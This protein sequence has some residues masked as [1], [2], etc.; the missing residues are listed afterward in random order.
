LNEI[1]LL[2]RLK[3]GDEK[4]FEEFFNYYYERIFNYVYRRI[5][6]KEVAEDIASET[7]LKFVRTLKDFELK[8]GYHLDTWIY[9]IA[10]NNVRDWFRRNLGY[11]T[12]PLEEKFENAYMPLLSDPY[13]SYTMENIHEILNTALNKLP[14]DYR[15]V[16]SMRFFENKSIKEIAVTLNKSESAVKVIQFRALK[17]LKEIIEELLNE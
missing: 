1:D 16:L 11:E 8:D 10:R 6:M 13:G 17:K 5:K 12:L 4:A 14:N 15:E 2:R 3:N 9:S 7:F